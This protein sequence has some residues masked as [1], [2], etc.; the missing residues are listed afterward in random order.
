M[1]LTEH[2]S[3]L[4]IV[5]PLIASFIN[6]FL[7]FLKRTLCYPFFLLVLGICVILSIDILST[8]ISFGTLRY[9]LGGW[10]PPW[11]IEYVVD[12]LNAYLIVIVSSI[13][14]IIAIY[15]KDSI[16]KE[17]A[18]AKLPYFYSTYLLLTTGLLGITITGDIFNLY[19]FLEIASL[20]AYALIAIGEKRSVLASFNYIIM[21]T[22]GA[23]F[24]LLGVGYIYIITGSLNISDLTRLLPSLYESKVTLTA[25][26]FFVVGI[27]IK[28]ALFPLHRW[29]PD[30]Y[31]FA[32]SAV[33]AF[34][35]ATVTKVGIY[36]LI[37]I[38]FTLFEPRFLTEITPLSN[39]LIWWSTIAIFFGSIIAIGQRDFKRTLSYILIAEIG[40]MVLGVSLGNKEGFIGAVLHILNDAVMI[41]CLFMI[42]GGI[43]YRVGS[44]NLEDF[45]GL[46]K[47]MPITMSAFIL[48]ALSM[49]GI[50]P[51]A[52]FFSKWY[53][54][55]G[56]IEAK[57]LIS[58]ATVVFSSLVNALIFF[59]IF[60]KIYFTKKEVI[61]QYTFRELPLSMMIP[62]IITALAILIIGFYSGEII[63]SIIKFTVP[64]GF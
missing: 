63:S 51:T 52:G 56:A 7:I 44:R 62:I 9:K 48:A 2:A 32:P 55:L 60:E 41:A 25:L 64:A 50:P 10:T 36:V 18:K 17:I 23:C 22:I 19:V 43:F 34:A 58:A 30:S 61:P 27:A 33:S 6:I 13:S 24:Y 14:F 42:A 47:N 8:V 31:T 3:I 28:I 15:S 16:K 45:T 26:A 1:N 21:G 53:L 29:L 57:Y 5:I 4:I 40:Y 20:S 39:M 38:S 37:R 11:G 49:I 54:I 46:N 35:S 12:H 59:R